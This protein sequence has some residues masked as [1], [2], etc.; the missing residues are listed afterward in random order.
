MAN[1]K[2]CDICKTFYPAH[3]MSRRA[4]GWDCRDS[5]AILLFDPDPEATNPEDM[6]D[7]KIELETCPLC[8]KSIKN[9]IEAIKH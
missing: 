9:F 2:Q 8:M 4:R 3:K 1:A 5:A 6:D 7:G